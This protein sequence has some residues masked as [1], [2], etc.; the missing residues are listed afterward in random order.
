MGRVLVALMCLLAGVG[1]RAGTAR[2]PVTFTYLGNA[3]WQIEAAHKIILVDP[4]LSEF[5][6]EPDPKE[7]DPILRPDQGQIDARDAQHGQA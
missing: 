2:E 3:G 6:P 4:Y 7:S 5:G 1:V